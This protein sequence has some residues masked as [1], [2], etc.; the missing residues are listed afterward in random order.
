M[1]TIKHLTGTAVHADTAQPLAGMVVEAVAREGQSAAVVGSAIISQDGSFTL[2]I[3]V[4]SA[5]FNRP[6]HYELRL[7]DG[8]RRV[9]VVDGPFEFASELAPER[10]ELRGR[11]H[12][13]PIAASVPPPQNG[14]LVQG[15]VR[16]LEGN[17][18]TNVGVRLMHKDPGAAPLQI[19]PV[20]PPSVDVAGDGS[21]EITG[22]Y[23]GTSSQM[24]LYI[25]VLDAQ[26]Q[27]I[28]VSA[29]R[30]RASTVERIDVTVEDPQYRASEFELLQ[31]AID[32]IIFGQ[33][34]ATYG[35]DDVDVLAHEVLQPMERVAAYIAAK[36]ISTDSTEFVQTSP[37]LPSAAA[38]YGWIRQGLPAN[39]A[40][41]SRYEAAELERT[42]TAAVDASMVP[43][44]LIVGLDVAHMMNIAVQRSKES[45][46]P[47]TLAALLATIS[48]S[49][50]SVVQREAFVD[51][52]AGHPGD[53]AGLWS[54]VDGDGTFTPTAIT[55][56]KRALRLGEFTGGYAEAVSAINTEWGATT[57]PES[58]AE[59]TEAEWIA[60]LS[61]QSVTPPSGYD[62]STTTLKRDAYGADI[63]A[64][65]ED[66]FGSRVVNYQ[67]AADEVPGSP[68]DDFL[69]VNLGFDHVTGNVKSE[70]TAESAVAAPDKD[71]AIAELKQWQ[72]LFKVTPRHGKYPLMKALRDAGYTSAVRIVH[73]GRPAIVKLLVGL[74]F[75]EAQADE[76]FD[77][78]DRNHAAAIATL[79]QH[80]RAFTR[81]AIAVLGDG[82][83]P[84]GVSGIPDYAELFGGGDS[85]CACTH[86]GSVFSPGAYFVDL[87]AWLDQRGVLD[88][89]TG[90]M[91][92]RPD[93][94]TLEL[95]CDNTH[96]IM[97][98]IDLV[99]EVLENAVSAFTAPT[100]S[101]R[102]SD[103]LLARPE[104]LHIDAYETL[105]STSITTPF[106]LGVAFADL[107]LDSLG[108]SRGQ[109]F[110]SFDGGSISVSASQKA[111][112][113]IGLSGTQWT[114]LTTDTSQAPFGFAKPSNVELSMSAGYLRIAGVDWDGFLDLQHSRF[115]FPESTTLVGIDPC[116]ISSYT[117]TG[118][119]SLTAQAWEEHH[120]KMLGA[121][122]ALGWSVREMDAVCAALGISSMT[123]ANL[124]SLVEA[125][126]TLNKLGVSPVIGSVLWGDLDT[127]ADRETAAPNS[128]CAYDQLFSDW[129]LPSA[130]SFA[131]NTGRTE[132]DSPPALDGNT[133]ASIA[134]A[135]GVEASLVQ[136]V[137]PSGS[138]TLNLAT[139]SDIVR[140]A[141]LAK[142][143]N[144]SGGA[145]TAALTAIPVD[146]FS[147]PASCLD[148]VE[149]V[150]ALTQ[151]AGSIE[152][153]LW[154]SDGDS[155][156]AA[157]LQPS[158]DAIS[159]EI[160]R[161]GTALA[162]KI[163]QIK[164]VGLSIVESLQAI[165][166]VLEADTGLPA[167]T[168]ADI[169]TLVEAVTD[170]DIASGAERTD[171]EAALD[172][173]EDVIGDASAI[174]AI[175]AIVVPTATPVES[176][177]NR[178]N[179]IIQPSVNAQLRRS[180]GAALAQAVGATLGLTTPVASALM[181]SSHNGQPMAEVLLNV[182]V[183][184]A[185]EP[186]RSAIPAAF[187]VW[188]RL[189]KVTQILTG[190][191]VNGSS[192]ALFVGNAASSFGAFA[193]DD[194][195]V[196][197]S[198]ATP[199][200]A[201][202]VSLGQVAVIPGAIN[203]V[204]KLA[205][206][207]ADATLVD[208]DAQAAQQS[209]CAVFFGVTEE[210]VQS[211]WTSAR[212]FTTKDS[213]ID[214]DRF[215]AL[216][217]QLRFAAQAGVSAETCETWCSALSTEA[218]AAS[219]VAVA[220]DVARSCMIRS[221]GTWASSAAAVRDSL[222]EMQRDALVRY[223]IADESGIESASDLYERYLLDVQMSACEQT[224]RMKLAI[225][226]VQLF[227]HRSMMG[228]ETGV[229]FD[230]EDV[231]QWEWMK[232]Y[233]VWEAGRKVLVYPE[234]WI[235]PELRDDK[236]PLFEAFE[237]EISK[238]GLQDAD[239]R[240]ALER[241]LEGLHELGNLRVVGM[242]L[243]ETSRDSEADI[244]HVVA[245]TASLPH[246]NYYITRTGRTW[247]AF[248][249]I[250]QEIP[251]DAI[252]PI[253][254]EG[255]TLLV[256]TEGVQSPTE[257]NGWDVRL[258]WS[259][260]GVDGFMPPKRS[261]GSVALTGNG[262][263][264]TPLDNYLWRTTIDA[265]GAIIGVYLPKVE[266]DIK[267]RYAP[268]AEGF[269]PLSESG[270][271]ATKI[272]APDSY[273][274][275]SNGFKLNPDRALAVFDASVSDDIWSA[276]PT[277]L[278]GQNTDGAFIAVC[279]T[280]VEWAS[281]KPFAVHA[282]G[283]NYLVTDTKP[284]RLAKAGGDVSAESAVRGTN[285]TL[286]AQLSYSPLVSSLAP[287]AA[288]R[289]DA[290]AVSARNASVGVLLGV[291]GVLG[292]TMPVQSLGEYR[293]ETLYH[294]FATPMLQ[295][296]RRSGVIALFLGSE[297]EAQTNSLSGPDAF[298]AYFDAQV[299]VSDSR[300]SE[301]ISFVPTNPFGRYNWELFFHAPLM[302]SQRLR[303]EKRFS[304]AVTWMHYLFDPRDDA[305][306]VDS[307]DPSKLIGFWKVRP[308][309]ED[310]SASVDAWKSLEAGSGDSAYEASLAAQQELDDQIDAWRKAPFKPHLIARLRRGVYQ[311]SVVFKYVETLVDWADSLFR[312]DTREALNEATNLYVLASQIVGELPIEISPTT[313]PA[314]VSWN[315]VKAG[316]WSL[317]EDIE[318]AQI[319]IDRDAD[320]APPV[321]AD[322]ESVPALGMPYFCVPANPKLDEIHATVQDR[323]F[324]LRNCMNIEG[325][326][327]QLPLFQPPID[328]ALL[329]RAAAAGLSLSSVVSSLALGLPAYRFTA[330]L[331]RAQSFVGSVRSLGQAMLGAWEKEDGEAL[332]ALRNT[333]E[334]AVIKAA[335][336]VRKSQVQ[337]ARAS[338][339]G[340]KRSIRSVEARLGHFSA[341]IDIGQLE[342]EESQLEAMKVA[343][344]LHGAADAV[345]TAS[346]ALFAVMPDLH[347]GTLAGIKVGAHQV[348]SVVDVVTT[349]LRG[350]ASAVSARGAIDGMQAGWAR[351]EQDWAQQVQQAEL[352]LKQMEKQ[353]LAAEIRLAIAEK[354][355][356]NQQL[357]IHNAQVVGDF[358][359][360]KFTNAQLYNWM[361]KELSYLY[362]QSYRLA[363]EIA[364]KAELCY[365][366]ELAD[367]SASFVQA[368]HWDSVHE[369]LLAGERLQLDLERMEA[370]YLANDVREREMTKHVSLAALNPTALAQ[371]RGAGACDFKVPETA[372]DMDVPG[373][374]LRRIK[375]V[376]ITI[377]CTKGTY[378]TVHA[379]LTLTKS[380][381]RRAP[382]LQV[383]PVDDVRPVES[384]VTSS[385]QDDSGLFSFDFND[386]RY[387]PFERRGAVSEWS[388]EFCNKELRGFD[389]STISDVVVSIRYT[390]RDGGAYFESKVADGLVA[391]LNSLDVGEGSGGPQVVVSAKR[392]A[393]DAFDAFLFPDGADHVLSLEGIL[394][395]VPY[396][397]RSR[398]SKATSVRAVVVVNDGYAPS[399]S[400]GFSPVDFRD[401]EGTSWGTAPTLSVLTV[402]A[403][404]GCP[405]T[406]VAVSEDFPSAVDMTL[407]GFSAA[408]PGKTEA[409]V[410]DD[411]VLIFETELS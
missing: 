3:D 37:T 29:L 42:L 411:V 238:T 227:V 105:R 32:P 126:V 326:V 274:S 152:A 291:T 383:D 55:A 322:L 35:L 263:A 329:V 31:T 124:Q 234:N 93:L 337:E 40:Q 231:E 210:D 154:V 331:G 92:K 335:M 373:Q 90:L 192:I 173:L 403:A 205:S 189:N 116:E 178:A 315:E 66:V 133:V 294:P 100:A 76:V 357:Q 298:S 125:S 14:V 342:G 65:V 187:E 172:K 158:D 171:R 359:R 110:D 156:V 257:T 321:E 232:N 223:L 209:V 5:R 33:D 179:A 191:D 141:V 97:P 104:H 106:D 204:A 121:M 77:N 27:P 195:P 386:P 10:A 134:A 408:F 71:T 392:D 4:G 75:S 288:D 91:G 211:V 243:E 214:A 254:L 144:V 63:Y 302:I 275:T 79:M 340:V 96:T 314:A 308:L 287:S 6:T 406:Q 284:G 233:R 323:L 82:P 95:S 401:A 299:S 226:S 278:L 366:Y 328:P 182:D 327:R 262:E 39:L 137:A 384:V 169:Q 407:S 296:T 389:W 20:G 347:I 57:T 117:L 267:F 324:K 51:H 18:V 184:Q 185:N 78:A 252:L 102:S 81:G 30:R 216:A 251:S 16:H 190:L 399:G 393:P 164:G 381:T 239:A 61:T 333:H 363:L 290:S 273:I 21:F 44:T 221:G 230:N 186:A 200:I 1:T 46:I 378:N 99:M 236:T 17:P 43:L 353:E 297:F 355:L 103:E 391:K 34:L 312:Q 369:G 142:A 160:G 62:Q 336:E 127:Y 374:Y 306:E 245:R 225:A 28:A 107:L 67:I 405:T 344:G 394:E 111:A 113:A 151:A 170:K 140:K 167:L 397:L 203:I 139:L 183:L 115:A 138:V 53:N 202:L 282:K 350:H 23:T 86:C 38:I 259:E 410:I 281:R 74:G 162:E 269:E 80:H 249:P 83:D 87:L 250:A 165:L 98:Y 24:M 270:R 235:E 271:G 36:R 317:E 68:V 208:A 132:L 356:S 301:D 25:E 261:K 334:V 320:S 72:R 303:T 256:W 354:E 400:F 108:L 177:E 118:G 265:A 166:A 12:V 73:A 136:A 330:M 149:Q 123:S 13:T 371:L 246:Q 201:G 175:K 376:T 15:Y 266:K 237:R 264:S 199:A 280:E 244:L 54:A 292:N 135:I 272:L 2:R 49:T 150:A 94:Q 387:V 194:V 119:A 168:E 22:D 255:R 130:S 145:L 307:S 390:A 352:E 377:P 260:L 276:T 48:T 286:G 52:V 59:K 364:Q 122:G 346:A 247:S 163:S 193:L 161:L 157:A 212:G 215:V 148:F 360:R 295:T 398:I 325:R 228:L 174:A 402:D 69:S 26:Q 146:P 198:S 300:P 309:A 283:R 188:D 248:Q 310:T 120:R 155:D 222:R 159:L 319:D 240:A 109:L 218:S 50:V 316:L 313:A 88:G 348:K 338:L 351:R 277:T 385:A 345:S 19:G 224:S 242:H 85:S 396:A 339:D 268:D 318:N 217:A 196:A 219:T 404:F 131:L 58:L 279:H 176:V 285:V 181:G 332:A 84:D 305:S 153:A 367:D 368:T 395:R 11:P 206:I 304:D 380:S 362:G 358:M 9:P 341:L 147:T 220:D 229:S 349:G 370:A 41:L 311:R 112:A 197:G 101:T 361:R 365:R 293:F 56:I 241:Y 409:D 60:M 253:V 180:G 379:R 128:P 47:G 7:V 143:L 382:S 289:Y 375:G 70:V 258:V 207:A 89:P 343:R 8:G 213:V 114:Y 45:G 64:N 372:F 388:L 129:T